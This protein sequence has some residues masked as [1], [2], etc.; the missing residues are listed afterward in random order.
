MMFFQLINSLDPEI[1]P[2]RCKIHLA[3]TPGSR[4]SRDDHTNPLDHYFAG[5]FDEWQTWQN[6]QNF[7]REF[8]LSLIQL[9]EHNKWLFVGIF[10]SQSSVRHEGVKRHKYRYKYRLSRRAALNE[11][12]GRLIVHYQRHGRQ[13]YRNAETLVDALTISE[14]RPEKMSIGE[15]PGY[16]RAMLTKQRLDLVV[17]QEIS[18]WK[19]ALSNVAG[20]YII[21]DQATG[22]LY[23]GSA[24]GDEGIWGRWRTYSATGHGGDKELRQLLREKGPAYA[25]KFQFGI[26]EIADTNASDD[27][28]RRR[29][30]RWKELLLT[31]HP[32]GY[33]AN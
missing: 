32:H 26:L 17:R 18:S 15:F 33:N 29:E 23:V 24:T 10:D 5:K 12:E 21:A 4:K 13:S 14:Y 20:V 16:S 3:V 9:P 6:Q 1:S 7:K 8:V 30:S 31:R 27:D 11:L 2:T 19:A 22:K 28:V 25:E